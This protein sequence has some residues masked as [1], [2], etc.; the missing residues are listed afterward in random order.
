MLQ[1]SLHLVMDKK[2][3]NKSKKVDIGYR[4]GKI[5]STKFSF[6]DISDEKVNNLFNS[7]DSLGVNISVSM[8][9]KNEDS[10]IVID[11]SS[12]LM[13]NTEGNVLI[14]HTGR[15]V[16]F[17]KGLEKVFNSKNDSFDL[18]SELLLQLLSIAYTHSRAL[19]A[20]EISPTCY[21]EKYFLPVIDPRNLIDMIRDSKNEAG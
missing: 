18:P 14:E 7:E 15:T 1:I 8:S 21:H 9:I 3:Q 6:T 2:K 13:D 19:L 16:Y 20:S 11:I 10:S 5:H 12:Q 4:I 17:I